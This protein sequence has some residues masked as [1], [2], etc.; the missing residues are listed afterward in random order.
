MTKNPILLGVNIDH[1]ATL[2]QAR[3]RDYSNPCGGI[4][5]PDPLMVALLAE[6]AGADGITVHLR[7]DRRHIQDR[8]VWR[9]RESI[10]TRLNLEMACTDEM[11]TFAKELRPDSV[12]LVP[13][14]RSEVTTEG[15]LDVVGQKGR[16]AKIADAM[17][18]IGVAVSLFIDPDADQVKM[19]KELKCP[20]VELHTGAYSNAYGDKTK[21]SI[22]FR[23]LEEAALLGY[24]LGIKVNAGH[25][26]NYVNIAEVRTIDHLHELNIGHSILCRSICT[27][28]EESVREMKRLMN[29]G[30][31]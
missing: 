23:R 25:G 27:G 21:Q 14:N 20:F 29:W 9:L 13:E 4:V 19:A 22:E 7:E 31:A 24:D 1:S 26:I 10:K 3:Y 15:G 18:E 5:E 11:L 16:V 12:C 6:Q 2:R 17:A 8:D 30:R 28:I